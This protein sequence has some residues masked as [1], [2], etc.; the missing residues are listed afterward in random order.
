MK[1]INSLQR[2]CF[3]FLIVL[4]GL[5]YANGMQRGFRSDLGNNQLTDEDFEHLKITHPFLASNF[6]KSD[7]I[8]ILGKYPLPQAYLVYAK[9]LADLA[10]AEVDDSLEA[11]INSYFCSYS[12]ESVE[13][14]LE[15]LSMSEILSEQ[16]GANLLACYQKLDKQDFAIYSGPQDSALY[17]LLNSNKAVRDED[18]IFAETLMLASSLEAVEASFI[19]RQAAG[20]E[21]CFVVTRSANDNTLFYSNLWKN[22]NNQA[23]MRLA[24]M[25]FLN[26]NR[27][28]K[29]ALLSFKKHINLW[30]KFS[31]WNSDE[32]DAAVRA[33]RLMNGKEDAQWPDQI[34]EQNLLSMLVIADLSGA[35]NFFEFLVIDLLMRRALL[36]K[37]GMPSLDIATSLSEEYA[38]LKAQVK[39]R[40]QRCESV[41]SNSIENIY[42]RN[43]DLLRECLLIKHRRIICGKDSFQHDEKLS[44]TEL[45]DATE[46]GTPKYIATGIEWFKKCIKRNTTYQQTFMIFQ[47]PC[48]DRDTLDRIAQRESNGQLF[49]KLAE[50]A[51]FCNLTQ[52][53]K[54]S[55]MPEAFFDMYENIL[56]VI[57]PINYKYD[58]SYD[59]LAEIDLS[60][61]KGLTWEHIEELKRF[62][63]LKK[64]TIKKCLLEGGLP[65]WLKENHQNLRCLDLRGNNLAGSIPYL[66][67]PWEGLDTLILAQN[68]LTGLIPESLNQWIGLTHLDLSNNKLEGTLPD[69]S[70]IANA[71]YQRNDSEAQPLDSYIKYFNV[72]NNNID[73]DEFPEWLTTLQRRIG[74]E[75]CII[76][77]QNNNNLNCLIS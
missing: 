67:F 32:T 28:D 12:P 65:L 64:L 77:P 70:P 45:L 61:N 59:L 1:K 29:A 50:A 66:L 5:S 39:C 48:V 71:C 25:N 41:T 17:N 10:K 76:Y 23:C 34:D 68:N 63:N 60:D 40:G 33:Y 9:K 58:V 21:F 46:Y 44:L 53:L 38:Q 4:V 2:L 35:L 27:Y 37:S 75:N 54:L 26:M 42:L 62:K 31:Q 36:S 11:K 49:Y 57:I 69:L 74:S 30:F 8:W 3:A 55:N 43:E 24:S 52:T 16:P 47:P 7:V 19:L 13:N 18:S 22:E 51:T 6:Q 56:D 20:E 14:I 73:L 72:C 15:L